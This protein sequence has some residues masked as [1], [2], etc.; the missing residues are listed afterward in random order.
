VTANTRAAVVAWLRRHPGAGPAAISAGTGIGTDLVKKA[1]NRAIAAGEA[2]RDSWGSYSAIAR[3]H[4]AAV[5]ASGDG[6]REAGR[7]AAEVARVPDDVPAGKDASSPAAQRWRCPCCAHLQ[8]IGSV[9][10]CE[11]CGASRTWGQP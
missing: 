7:E 9:E 5:H 6:Q 10:A 3:R 1:L 2:R 11:F 8:A 4:L